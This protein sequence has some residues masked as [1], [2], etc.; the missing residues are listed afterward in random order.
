MTLYTASERTLHIEAVTRI[1]KREIE[2]Q[3]FA[4][5]SNENSQLV[6]SIDG[7]VLT[8][9]INQSNRQDNQIF[10]RKEQRPKSFCAELSGVEEKP[11]IEKEIIKAIPEAAP[12]KNEPIVTIEHE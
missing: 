6:N 11:E 3:F 5:Q 2:P 8:L 9:Q 10:H 4:I 7:L 12:I 1:E